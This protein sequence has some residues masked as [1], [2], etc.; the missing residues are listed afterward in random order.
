[1]SGTLLV[2]GAR[3]LLTFR[4]TAEPRRGADLKELGVIRDA[5]LLIKDGRIVEVGLSR[6]IE[7]LVPARLAHVIDVTGQVVMPGFV[8][9]H[10]HPVV[11]LP[12]ADEEEDGEDGCGPDRGHAPML[13]AMRNASARRLESRA[14]LI[15]DGMVRHGTTTMEAKSGHGMD[16]R[17][18]VKALRVLARLNGAPLDISSA[19]LTPHSS[20]NVQ[21]CN[22]ATYLAWICRDFLPGVRRRSLARFAALRCGDYLNAEQARQFLRTARGLGFE[23]KIHVGHC[24]T[25]A[26]VELAVEMQ[27]T[28]VDNICQVGP[29]EIAM[30]AGSGSVAVLL[31]GDA[32][33]P[34][35]ENTGVSGSVARRLITG[36]AAVALGSNFGANISSTYS[37]AT[38][39]AMA[40]THL[41]MNPAEAICAA[42]YNA[43]CAMGMQ[44][45][46]G[47]IEVGKPAD[48][49]VL[50]ASD[51]RE[52]PYRYGVNLVNRTV[53][54]GITAYREGTV[55]K[56]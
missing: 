23:L 22:P 45:V 21:G 48:F 30:L 9:C 54:R 17:E 41:G 5:A 18:E 43:A 7:N 12:L 14:R 28:S 20:L 52:I 55:A 53:K 46:A 47:S 2:R 37:M 44:H 6:R 1:M 25:G 39:V 31:P 15:V 36:N 16:T 19:V 3:Q 24:A 40:C 8:D 34:N 42:T 26:A 32:I 13:Q 11:G 33:D 50:N 27:A 29:A 4:G 51:Y 49:I 10:A 56:G 38:I 35:L